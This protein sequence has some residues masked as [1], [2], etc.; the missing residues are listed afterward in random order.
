MK[1]KTNELTF[2]LVFINGATDKIMKKN[3]KQ[4]HIRFSWFV[5]KFRFVSLEFPKKNKEKYR[6]EKGK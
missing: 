5:M 1:G 2:C 3:F 4:K 6:K